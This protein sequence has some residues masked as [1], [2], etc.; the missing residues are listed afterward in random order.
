MA[1]DRLLPVSTTPGAITGDSY[2]DAVQEEVTALW[3]TG[4]VITLTAVAGTNTITATATP[5]MT[6]GLANGMNFIL[7]AAATNTTSVTLN[8]N[9]G[10]AVAVVDGE[11]TALIAGAIRSGGHYLLNYNSTS[12]HFRIVG[13]TPAAV[14]TPMAKLLA[15]V[16]PLSSTASFDFVHGATPTS[17]SGTVTASGTVVLDDTYDAYEL[18]LSN[19]APSTDDVEAWLRIGTGGGPTYATTTYQYVYHAREAN[20]TDQTAQSTS[21][22]SII[23]GMS[24]AATKAVGNAAVETFSCRINFDNPENATFYKHFVFR[25]SYMTSITTLIEFS[26][27]GIW[28]TA[29]AIT[30]IRFMFES[31]NIASG[32]ASLYGFTKA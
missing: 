6:A 21:A 25:G 4:T 32:R 26:G 27:S 2:M 16:V 8:I 11:G 19:L 18:V 9:G 12:T 30:A 5:A 10:G 20:A 22:S 24:T 23:L 15:T 3:N 13:Y 1:V 7:R 28:P 14:T 31:G 29:T 17:S